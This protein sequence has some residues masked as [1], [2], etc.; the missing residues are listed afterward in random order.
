MPL[1]I[2]TLILVVFGLIMMFS[3]SYANAI[4]YQDNAY[5]YIS[6]QLVYAIIGLIGMFIVSRVDYGIIQKSNWIIYF[7][8][9]IMLIITLFMPEINGARRWIIFGGFTFQPSEVAKFATIVLIASL[10]ARYPDRMKKIKYGFFQPLFFVG[11]FLAVTLNQT[12]LSGSIIIISIAFVMMFAGGSKLRWFIVSGLIVL[13]LVLLVLF[14]MNMIDGSQ[15]ETAIVDGDLVYEQSSTSTNPIIARA[16]DRIGLWLDPFNHE[17]GYQTVQSLIAIGSGGVFGLGLGNS[18]Q[19]HLYV[20]EPQNDFIFAI[21]CEELGFVGAVFVIVLFMLFIFRGFSIA[22]KA[23][24]KF[25]ALVA[26]GITAQVGIQTIFNIAVVSNTV[27]NT[28]ISLPFFSQ[29][30]T[31]LVILL[32]EVGVLLS[33]SRASETNFR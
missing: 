19:K 6:S 11:L 24:D 1:L 32:L 29:G 13:G 3:A 30:G 20:P 22:L 31:S 25:G 17:Y 27:P 28:G 12:H 8:S 23:R 10:V 16:Q 9:L 15:S 21:T 4:Y 2:V 33:I 5:H 7:I 18:R 14:A 26:L